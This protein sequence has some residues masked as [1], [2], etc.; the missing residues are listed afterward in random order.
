LESSISAISDASFKSNSSFSDLAARD[1]DQGDDDQGDDNQGD[2]NQGDDDSNVNSSFSEI[3]TRCERQLSFSDI[4]E[5]PEGERAGVNGGASGGQG[6]GG[7]QEAKE[8]ADEVLELLAAKTFDIW[9]FGVLLYELVS[10]RTLFSTTAELSSE[11]AALLSQ[12]DMEH[13][14]KA[15]QSVR[16]EPLAKDLLCHTLHPYPHERYD[17]FAMVLAHPFL[18]VDASA[19]LV[20]MATEAALCDPLTKLRNKDAFVFELDRWRLSNKRYA[21]ICVDLASFQTMNTVMGRRAGDD[22]LRYFS[23]QLRKVSDEVDFPCQAFRTGADDF[24]LLA[25]PPAEGTQLEKLVLTLSKLRTT[26]ADGSTNT[27]VESW[28][29]VGVVWRRG[30]THAEARL[31]E[32]MVRDR[33]RGQL[34]VEDEKQ[35]LLQE[36][37]ANGLINYHMHCEEKE[38]MYEQAKRSESIIKPVMDKLKAEHMQ[39]IERIERENRIAMQDQVS[40][41]NTLYAGEIDFKTQE[42]ANS[43]AEV[44]Q[45]QQ[46]LFR[47]KRELQQLEQQRASSFFG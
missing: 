16:S 13:L 33:I 42:L 41:M 28:C 27:T 4:A 17:D 44:K 25:H 30:G 46:E 15:L 9:S 29:R 37:A 39:A 38:F 43:R 11:D 24:V 20:A 45:L 47:T 2:D 8:G 21:L 34:G 26:R 1:D 10:G 40:Q 35:V 19:Q 18:D 36:L 6:P 3:A 23:T 31:V 22:V 32:M 12:W 5:R 7:A 14:D